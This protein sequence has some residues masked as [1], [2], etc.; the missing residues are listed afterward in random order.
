VLT[1]ISR[2]WL[3]LLNGAVVL[4]LAGGFAAPWLLAS[5]VPGPANALYDLYAALCHQWASRSFFVFGP[6]AIYS[7]DALEALGVDPYRFA[8]DHGLGWKMGYC[9]RDLAIFAGLLVFGALY[10]LRLRPAGLRPAG[11]LT[12]VLLALPMALDGGTQLLGQRESTW[13]LR[14]AT[15]LVFGLASGW[16]MYPRFETSFQKALR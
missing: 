6:R 9:E 8:G 5:G 13:E 11:Y 3:G 15:G 10:A 14:L 1:G 7:H 12:F 4:F 16:L 2:H